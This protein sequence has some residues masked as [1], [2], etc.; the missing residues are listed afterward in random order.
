M[1]A[2]TY[3]FKNEELSPRF[4]LMRK[5]G[6]TLAALRR[7]AATD[8]AK[9]NL[10][11]YKNPDDNFNDFEE[12]FWDYMLDLIYTGHED[13]AWQYFDLVWPA[14]KAGKERFR[15]DFK[16]QLDSSAYG[17]WKRMTK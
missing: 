8:R 10:H 3:E 16:K 6:P 12:P 5:P 17:D 11:P 15:A 7:K 4:D 14:K 9:I 2:V 13:L 1:P